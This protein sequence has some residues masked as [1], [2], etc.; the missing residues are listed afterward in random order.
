MVMYCY[1]ADSYRRAEK[2]KELVSRYR[3]RNPESDLQYFDIE[4][5]PDDIDV[6]M[7]FLR[8]PTLFCSKKLA[9]VRGGADISDKRWTKTL[10]NLLE[11][12]TIFVLV[13]GAHKPARPL[14]FLLKE[15]VRTWQFEELSDKEVVP[16]IR[17]FAQNYS[18]TFTEDAMQFLS[19]YALAMRERSWRLSREIEK[20]SLLTSP[21]NASALAE[22]IQWRP[23]GVFY[24][25]VMRFAREQS[26]PRR[27]ILLEKLFE[28]REDAEYVF[29]MLGALVRGRQAEQLAAYDVCRKS[30]KLDTDTSL[31][32][33]ALNFLP[34]VL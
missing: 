19:S 13:T 7:D 20:A 17:Q 24:E 25:E 22:L 23:E 34:S 1:G 28:R 14:A 5:C 11:D 12:D 27:I 4:E 33:F 3:E 10:K 21:V 8:Q 2:T 9:V 18:V 30:G 6:V 26:V 15:S 31:F 16:F 29:N 32:A